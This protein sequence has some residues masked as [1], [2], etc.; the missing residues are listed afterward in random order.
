[1]SSGEIIIGGVRTFKTRLMVVDKRIYSLPLLFLY[2]EPPV[3][4]SLIVNE[5][6]TLQ[7]VLLISK[8]P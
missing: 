4:S 8:A 1:M 5:V 3:M 7:C 2:W 6:R